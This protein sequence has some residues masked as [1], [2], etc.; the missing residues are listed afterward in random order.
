MNDGEF[1]LASCLERV[2]RR[3]EDAARQLVEHLYPLV[4]KIVRSHHAPRLGEEDMAQEIFAK[5]FLKL[6]Q[7]RGDVPFEHWVSRVAVNTCLN[8]LRALKA[9]PELRWSDLGE[10]EAGALEATLAGDSL[11]A[12]QSVSARDLV[13]KLLGCLNA[14]DRLVISL[15]DLEERSV[16]EVSAVTGWGKSM[17][18]VRCFR[19]R[20]KLRKYLQRLNNKV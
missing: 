18:K 2:R 17:V 14:E 12:E 10:D 16:A 11:P 9:R 7:Y 19:A 4:I 5:V 20:R 1:D 3:D 6:E 13:E 8:A 15:M